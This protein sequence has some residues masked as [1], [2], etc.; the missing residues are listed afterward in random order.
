MWELIESFVRVFD[1]GPHD[2]SWDAL[3][4][5][6][7]VKTPCAL[8]NGAYTAFG[9]GDVIVGV[10]YI[11]EV[12]RKSFLIQENSRSPSTLVMVKPLVLYRLMTA[13]VS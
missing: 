7:L 11:D 8:L 9:F 4:R 1:G 10:G 13:F 3:E 12:S 5:Q 2:G 6:A